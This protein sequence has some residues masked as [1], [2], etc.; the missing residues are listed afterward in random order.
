VGMFE[1]S[2]RWY[3]YQ[4]ID[5]RNNEAFYVGKGTGD[6]LNAH[7]REALKGACSRKCNR[8]IEILSVNLD[9][10]AVKVAYFWDEQAAYDFETDLFDEIGLENLTNVIPGGSGAW[11]MR[12]EERATRKKDFDPMKFIESRGDLI[13]IWLKHFYQQDGNHKKYK[14]QPGDSV[15]QWI[16]GAAFNAFIP[17]CFGY[18]QK[19]HESMERLVRAVRP[20]GVELVF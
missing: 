17:M 5:P 7:K 6:R 20:Y 12:L 15:A 10:L 1:K 9:V 19:R 2:A 11:T 18:A 14:S 4:L 8:I 13:A 3:V 16:I